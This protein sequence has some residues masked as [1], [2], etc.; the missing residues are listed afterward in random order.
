LTFEDSK[1]KTRFSQDVKANVNALGAG[2]TSHMGAGAMP[3]GKN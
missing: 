1:T 2:N 3:A